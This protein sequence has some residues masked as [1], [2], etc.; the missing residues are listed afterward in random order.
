MV[1]SPGKPAGIGAVTGDV[2]PEIC[3]KNCAFEDPTALGLS[4]TLTVASSRLRRSFFCGDMSAG[5]SCR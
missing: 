2:R 4:I 3:M 5:M 1:P